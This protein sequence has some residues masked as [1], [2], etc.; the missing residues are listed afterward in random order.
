MRYRDRMR[1]RHCYASR[2]AAVTFSALI[3][4][5]AGGLPLFLW[6]SPSPDTPAEQTA[7]LIKYCSG[8]HNERLRTGGVFFDK[9][10]VSD[11]EKNA[12][13]LEKV[14]HKLR[15]GEMPPPGM[16]R[17]DKTALDGFAGAL[18]V[19]LD[20]AAA[21]KPWPGRVAVHRLNRTEYGNA[22]RDLLALDIDVKTLLSADGVDERG[23]DNIAGI[24][25]VSP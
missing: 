1:R 24:L 18:E 16:P 11:V 20:R 19:S 7:L 14:A 8:C 12:E 25:T 2:R 3:V 22:I 13:L 6:S 4:L 17:P 23:F 10:T 5:L 15:S 9:T 21:A